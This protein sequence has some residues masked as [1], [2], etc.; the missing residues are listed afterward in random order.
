M[1]EPWKKAWSWYV[2]L[3]WGYFQ[4]VSDHGRSHIGPT[5]QSRGAC[6]S[7]IR[8]GEGNLHHQRSPHRKTLM[9][10]YGESQFCFWGILR[11]FG[12]WA[13]VSL[14]LS[15]LLLGFMYIDKNTDYCCGGMTTRDTRS[16]NV[17]CRRH[18]PHL[19]MFSN[20]INNVNSC[21][22]FYYGFT[23]SLVFRRFRVLEHHFPRWSTCKS[24]LLQHVKLPRRSRVG[25]IEDDKCVSRTHPLRTHVTTLIYLLDPC[26]WLVVLTRFFRWR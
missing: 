3:Q 13:C 25:G 6:S 12:W 26:I 7:P 16:E 1:P 14:R 2:Y 22:Y 11:I 20:K 9:M 21:D 18:L 19:F 4:F 10:L 23:Q 24:Q 5:Q 8:G 15:F 17:A